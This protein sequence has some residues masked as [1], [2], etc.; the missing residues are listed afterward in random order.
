VKARI[1]SFIRTACIA[2]AKWLREHWL[3][4]ITGLVMTI[5]LSVFLGMTYAPQGMRYS[6]SESQQC[7]NSPRLFPSLARQESKG[8]FTISRPT[9]LSIGSVPLYASTVCARTA[10]A[11]P[12]NSVVTYREKLLGVAW[13]SRPITIHTP[14]Y[15]TIADYTTA[16]TQVAPDRPLQFPLTTFDGTFGYTIHA[17][18]K[19]AQCTARTR[20]VTCDMAA[21]QL[22]YATNYKLGIVRHFRGKVVGKL[23]PLYVRTLT[24][25]L[26]AATTIAANESVERKPT[27][28]TL[29]LDKEVIEIGTVRLVTKNADG[30]ET[31][32]PATAALNERTIS[33]KFGAE[34]SRKAAFELRLTDTRAADDSGLPGGMYVLPF[35]TSGGP[36]VKGTTIGSYGLGFTQPITLTFDQILLPTQ[37]GNAAVSLTVNGAPWPAVKTISDT[38][39]TI[40]PT[41]AMPACAVVAVAAT[42]AVQNQHG[43]SGDSAWSYKSR[44][45][46]Y[47]TFSIG[48]SVRGRGLTAYKFGSGPASILYVGAMH[49]SEGNSRQLMVEWI[50]ELNRHP[51]RLP[52]NKTLVIIPALNPDGLASGSRFNANSVD[53]N[54]NFPANDWKSEVTTPNNPQ[55]SPAGGSA[56]LSEPESRALAN[57]IGQ[58][59]PRLVMSF[60]SKA[61][62]VEA[63]EA[64]DSVAIAAHYAKLSRY[65]AVPKSQSVGIFQYDTTGALEDW[66]RDKQGR[67]AIVVELATSSSSEFS[68]NQSALW[69]TVGL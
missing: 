9:T 41:A 27:D 51:D 38:K 56:P 31:A 15:P 25:L 3:R 36:V 2:Y 23:S 13:A 50:N 39:I 61:A 42:A 48:S 28:I 10:K 46:C 40:R 16:I 7:V 66:L 29:T 49:G 21:L 52:A 12:A 45:T 18:D 57:Y 35:R 6:F 43:V 4:A 14:A 58:L 19:V 5:G 68:R 34:L 63:N 37:D 59:A 8:A 22:A 53:L 64:G 26:V 17:G 32:I 62:V 1:F 44:T 69:Y 55:P 65:R 20:V 30:T 47:T 11:P 33:V 67:A 60:H 24:P 54:R